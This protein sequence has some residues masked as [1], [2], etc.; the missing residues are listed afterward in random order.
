MTTEAYRAYVLSM[1]QAYIALLA[2]WLGN[3]YIA[4]WQ[5]VEVVASRAA[6][7]A[8]QAAHFSSELDR[9][10]LQETGLSAISS[11][12]TYITVDKQIYA[13]SRAMLAAVRRIAGST[14]SLVIE[15]IV[16]HGTPVLTGIP[17]RALLSES[18]MTGQA[19]FAGYQE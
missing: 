18:D 11:K 17:A 9:L 8:Q 6:H 3:R 7:A 15:W 19:E 1:Q 14:E 12:Q 2:Y 10:A 13:V 4:G 5:T 16:R